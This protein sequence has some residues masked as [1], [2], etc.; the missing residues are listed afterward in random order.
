MKLLQALMEWQVNECT[1]ALDQSAA[2]NQAGQQVG[3][4]WEEP[5]VLRRLDIILCNKDRVPS[6]WCPPV[7]LNYSFSFW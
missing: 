7:L 3:P 4:G 1:G 5:H 6:S 2:R